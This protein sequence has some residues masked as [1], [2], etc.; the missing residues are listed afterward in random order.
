MAIDRAMCLATW[1]DILVVRSL[2]RSVAVTVA[3]TSHNI[4]E[5][6]SDDVNVIALNAHIAHCGIRA[7]AIFRETIVTIDCSNI[8]MSH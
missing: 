3:F 6:T 7:P 8:E 2:L 1:H 4:S 5:L